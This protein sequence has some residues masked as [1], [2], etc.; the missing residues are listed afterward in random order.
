MTFVRISGNAF[1][2]EFPFPRK[3]SILLQSISLW[4]SYNHRI[5]VVGPYTSTDQ[6]ML[7]SGT[8]QTEKMFAL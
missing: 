8:F 5:E 1:R 4:S 6:P 2:S 3:I 7:I